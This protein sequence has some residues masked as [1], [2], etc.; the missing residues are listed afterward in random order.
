ML[1]MLGIHC[2]FCPA[3]TLEFFCFF[4]HRWICLQIFPSALCLVSFCLPWN[5]GNLLRSLFSVIVEELAV[6]RSFFGAMDVRTL[7]EANCQCAYWTYASMESE[8]N[9]V[10]H[11]SARLYPLPFLETSCW[12]SCLCCICC[13]F[14]P[15]K[16][17]FVSCEWICTQLIYCRLLLLL[18]NTWKCLG[19]MLKQST[20]EENIQKKL[21]DYLE[22]KRDGLIYMPSWIFLLFVQCCLFQSQHESGLNDCGCKGCSEGSPVTNWTLASLDSYW[23]HRHALVSTWN[24][25]RE[26]VTNKSRSI[27]PSLLLHLQ[28]RSPW[29]FGPGMVLQPQFIWDMGPSLAMIRYTMT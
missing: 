13:T 9:W 19:C 25:W 14:A 15:L 10:R 28:W 11:T 18:T 12:Y 3:E 16:I 29:D 20:A 8:W 2:L 7:R 23:I 1:E 6:L 26:K 24:E 4:C 22:K 27:L 21:N 17:T 5:S